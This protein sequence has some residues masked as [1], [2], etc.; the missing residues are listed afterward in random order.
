MSPLR[1]VLAEITT[2]RGGVRLD[3]V[4]RRVGVSRAEVDSMIEYWVRRGKLSTE[5][6]TSGCPTG[7]CGTCP[8]TSSC[9]TR[10]AGPVL[11]AITP[12]IG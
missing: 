8:S 5:A 7:G 2:A 10:P 6:I 1:Q 11:I 12:R 3:D 4:A 9:G